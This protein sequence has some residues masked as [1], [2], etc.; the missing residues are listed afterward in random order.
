MNSNTRPINWDIVVVSSLKL[1]FTT[2]MSLLIF[3]CD[4]NWSYKFFCSAT[5]ETSL[6]EATVLATEGV[7][8]L[9]GQII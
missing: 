6:D 7:W 3:T 4:K 8:K 1:Q 5:L 9:F 2:I